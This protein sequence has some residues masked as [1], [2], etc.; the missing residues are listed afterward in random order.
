MGC[1]V[2]GGAV[3]TAIA[4]SVRIDVKAAA[5][6]SSGIGCPFVEV[7]H[8]IEDAFGSDASDFC[9]C[10]GERLGELVEALV[11]DFGKDGRV[12]GL[13]VFNSGVDGAGIVANACLSG[14]SVRVCPSV[15]AL[16]ST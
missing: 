1:G 8:H 3:E 14:V 10:F 4:I 11:L 9:A 2:C 16:T 15:G 5:K 6:C 7:A 12:G 13:K